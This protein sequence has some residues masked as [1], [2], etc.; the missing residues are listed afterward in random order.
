[1]RTTLDAWEILH[2]VVQLGGFAPAAEKLNRSQSTISYAVARLQDQLGVKLF[3]IRGRR[4]QLTEAGRVLLADI[5]PHLAGFHELEQR[6]QSLASGGASEI[7]LSVDSIFPNDR[8]FAAL[9]EFARLF[10]YVQP[11]LRQG[12]FLSADTEFSA[13]NAQL[14]ITGLVTREFFLRPILG[15]RLI[16][17]ARRDH[18]IHAIRRRLTRSDLMQSMLVTI[19]GAGVAKHQPRVPAQRVLPVSSIEAA[20][21]AV[22]SGLCFGWLPAY[23]IRRELDDGELL[24]LH[25]SAGR[26]REVRLNL[27]C[28]DLGAS[29]RE[30]NALAELLGI[31]READIL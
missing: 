7:R 14:C 26:T 9:A 3:E 22:R 30:V 28:K 13:H 19:E 2:A 31:N 12:T 17:V 25:L 21:D 8:L 10:P 15:I 5:E 29:S 1:M 27:V 23:R 4:A 20:I 24:P 11:R 6:A 18:P 16:A